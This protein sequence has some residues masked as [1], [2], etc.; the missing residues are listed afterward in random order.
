MQHLEHPWDDF[1]QDICLFADD[2]ICDLVREEQYTLQ[3]VQ[4]DRRHL[5]VF[6]LF[7]QELK[8]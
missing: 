4:K 2:F 5:V 8:G 7:L 3:P 6:V 1:L